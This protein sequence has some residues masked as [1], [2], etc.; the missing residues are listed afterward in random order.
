MVKLERGIPISLADQIRSDFADRARLPRAKFLT[1]GVD[2]HVFLVSPVGRRAVVYKL[3]DRTPLTIKQI[4][5]YAQ[6]TNLLHESLIKN[7]FIDHVS[8]GS[9]TWNVGFS[10]N[11][12]LGVGETNDGS[13]FTRS[14]FIEGKTFYHMAAGVHQEADDEMETYASEPEINI[15]SARED[16]ETV[17]FPKAQV[18][19]LFDQTYWIANKDRTERKFDEYMNKTLGTQYLNVQPLNIKPRV[20]ADSKSVHF[21]ITDIEGT[22]SDLIK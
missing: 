11:P 7:P 4:Q 3:Y 19:T 5:K 17:P 21:I 10:V 6:L 1:F 16:G 12:V 14:S 18:L 2:S 22:I 13:P 8:L 9:D 20:D 15:L